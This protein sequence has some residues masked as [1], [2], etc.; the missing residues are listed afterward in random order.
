MLTK[1][2]V[3]KTLDKRALN[4]YKPIADYAIIGDRR[5]CALV[6]IDGSIDWMCAPRFDSPSVFSSLLDKEKG[7]CFSI[8]PGYEG[9][10]EARQYYDGPTNVLLTEFRNENGRIGITDF[11]PCFRVSGIVVSSREL[12]R[13]IICLEGNFDL[14]V[15][16][17]PR[18][19]YGSVIP[20]IS[21]IG[22]NGYSFV[23]EKHQTE[24]QLALI[25]PFEFEIVGG[26]AIGSFA[27][28]NKQKIDLVLRMG[29]LTDYSSQQTHTDEKLAETKKYW[30]ALAAQ[31]DYRGK[32]RDYV[33][34]SSLVLHLLVYGPTG[35]IIAAPTTSLPEKIG[36]VRNWDYRY[37][38][39]RDSSFV[40]W[41]LHSI[42]DK[43]ERG[44]YLNWLTSI[45]YLTIENIQVMIGITGERVLNERELSHLE[46]Y[47][48]SSPVRI[49]NAAWNQPQLDVYG[50]LLD[51][52]YFAHK[53]HRRL[54]KKIFNHI[55]RPVV[56]LVEQ[57]W[58][59]PDRGIWEVRGEKEDFVYSKMWCWVALD[60][61]IK[62]GNL[63]GVKDDFSSW[64]ILRDTIKDTIFQKGWDESLQSFVRSFGSREVDAANLLM[65]Q[66]K[67]ID[68]KDP[69]FISTIDEIR[70]Q[71][72]R[73]GKFVYRYKT[74]DGLPGDE[75]AFLICSFWLVSCLALAGQQKESEELLENLIEY[76]NHVGLFSEEIDPVTG[77]LLG[78]FPQAFTHMGFISAVMDIDGQS[79]KRRRVAR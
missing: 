55:V 24:Q 70:K 49:G 10:F 3:W 65:P 40:L 36:G 68:G 62:L 21:K 31:C 20:K 41:A 77:A 30:R 56:K 74:S 42:G 23:S 46:G 12:H 34:R 79:K 53:H 63:I 2:Q 19:N 44:T 8:H 11:M 76:S 66:V 9:E 1:D 39:I 47:A 28:R 61:A 14:E 60:R 7:G 43:A 45:F 64:K 22:E 18:L 26:S 54:S 25:S 72:L 37:S 16:L 69:R 52:L 27:M 48:K 67:F 57:N 75:G 71:L 51:T 32:W 15:K 58:D 38:W 59:K 5:T 17:E 35:A 29:G 4:E 33:V 73:D 78:N 13:R 6:G 50:I